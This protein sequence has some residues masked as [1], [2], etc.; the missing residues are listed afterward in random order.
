MIIHILN[1]K[2]GKSYKFNVFWEFPIMATENMFKVR[3][4]IEESA[5]KF[6]AVVSPVGQKRQGWKL[7]FQ[8]NPPHFLQ[9]QN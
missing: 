3:H 2:P 9:A 8:Q 5:T 7:C 4:I 6:W 1:R